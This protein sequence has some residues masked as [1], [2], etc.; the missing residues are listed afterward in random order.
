MID[1]LLIGY[2]NDLGAPETKGTGFVVLRG[3]RKFLVTCRHVVEKLVPERIVA[4]LSPKEYVHPRAKS[5]SIK[6]GT[7]VFHHDDN[8]QSSRDVAVY[9]IEEEANIGGVVEFESLSTEQC[10]QQSTVVQV[11]GY[12]VPYLASRFNP[13]SN[14]PLAPETR[15]CVVK[16]IPLEH[17]QPGGFERSPSGIQFLQSADGKAI[18]EGTSGG[19]VLR[20]SDGKCLGM[21][22]ASVTANWTSPIGLAVPVN[23]GAFIPAIFVRQVIEQLQTRGKSRDGYQ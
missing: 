15:S 19:V 13:F 10:V 7:P 12:S 11:C 2:T 23:G 16:N 6:L 9:A 3:E 17:L 20:Q 8:D 1:L 4:I 21:L 22:V 5:D 18:N 14:Q